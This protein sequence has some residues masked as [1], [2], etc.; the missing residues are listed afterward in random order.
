MQPTAPKAL[1]VPLPEAHAKALELR[2]PV[3]VPASVFTDD[4]GWSLMNQLQG[5]MGPQGQVNFSV[6]YPG[7]IKAW[8]RH[9]LQTDFWIGLTGHLKAGIFR[10]DDGKAWLLVLGEK[11]PGVEAASGRGRY[12]ILRRQTIAGTVDLLAQEAE[13]ALEASRGDLALQ[14]A[15]RPISLDELCGVEAADRVGREI[16]EHR[17]RPVAVLQHAVIVAFGHDADE[18]ARALAPGVRQIAHHQ[19]ARDQRRLQLVAQQ[20]VQV[21]A[22]LVGA[23]PNE[24]RTDAVDA[25]PERLGPRRAG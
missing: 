15:R 6:Q 2:E 10:E 12:E 5:V 24:A 19:I 13:Q 23:G 18:G 3:F 21:I 8:H 14:V 1:S 16:A 17:R 7:V 20:Y 11:R 9:K 25:A 4:R 22:Q